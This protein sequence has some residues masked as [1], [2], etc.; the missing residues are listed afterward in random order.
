MKVL[1]NV[2]GFTDRRGPRELAAAAAIEQA[3][4]DKAIEALWRKKVAEHP[5]ERRRILRGEQLLA[6]RFS[7]FFRRQAT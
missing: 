1:M 7:R 3:R 5:V 4:A 2:V 6:P